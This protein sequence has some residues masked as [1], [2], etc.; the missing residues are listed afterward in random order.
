VCDALFPRHGCRERADFLAC[1]RETPTR[2]LGKACKEVDVDARGRERAEV[3]QLLKTRKPPDACPIC[4]D[5]VVVLLCYH[6]FHANC[7]KRAALSQ[8][9]ATGKPPTCAVCRE[10][11]FHTPASKRRREAAGLE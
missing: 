5:A 1:L 4:L 10:C 2:E 11:L 6:E 3:L 9:E 7:A 8:Y